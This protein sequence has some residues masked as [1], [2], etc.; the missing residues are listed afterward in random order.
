MQGFGAVVSRPICGYF[1]MIEILVPR[2]AAAGGGDIPPWREIA[3]R[4]PCR[5][6]IYRYSIDSHRSSI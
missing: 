3:A 1:G 5:C 2:H 4:P 6:F